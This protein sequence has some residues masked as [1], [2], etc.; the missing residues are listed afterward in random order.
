MYP[1]NC[2]T[3]PI[4]CPVYFKRLLFGSAIMYFVVSLTLGYV[5]V[6]AAVSG[7]V[8]LPE[9]AL[10][11]GFLLPFGTDENS[12]LLWNFVFIVPNTLF[13]L[14][15]YCADVLVLHGLTAVPETIARIEYLE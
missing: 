5:G 14:S 11:L 8:D 1:R 15:K 7:Y 3:A 13:L 9:F 6:T 12:D 10:G 2:H 4:Q